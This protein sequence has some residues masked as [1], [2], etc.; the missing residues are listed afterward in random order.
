[1]IKTSTIIEWIYE[2]FRETKYPGDNYLQGSFEG[3]EPLE[4]VAPY[5]NFLLRINLVYDPKFDEIKRDSRFTDLIKQS[6]L[7]LNPPSQ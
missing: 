2:G 1:M 7:T 4:T 3:C 5:Y 6:G